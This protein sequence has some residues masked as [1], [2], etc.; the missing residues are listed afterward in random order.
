MFCPVRP[1][2][3]GSIHTVQ[4]ACGFTLELWCSYSHQIIVFM[5]SQLVKQ[6]KGYDLQVMKCWYF[7]NDNY[8]F[9]NNQFDLYSSLCIRLLNQ[10]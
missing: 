2:S 3:L 6:K 7:Y 9:L 1:A 4:Q 8:V 10:V 5:T